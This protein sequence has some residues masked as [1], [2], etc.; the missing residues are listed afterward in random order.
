MSL[1]KLHL[2][3]I[4]CMPRKASLNNT[5]IQLICPQC[6][7]DRKN[8]K[9]FDSPKSLYHHIITVH[10]YWDNRKFTKKQFIK[11]LDGLAKALDLGVILR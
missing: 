11:M 7:I 8:S 4:D 5:E 1:G 10:K 2:S 6:V 9:K 3:L